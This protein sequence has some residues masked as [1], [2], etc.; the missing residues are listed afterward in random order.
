M[1]L[2]FT[3][4]IA[5]FSGLVPVLLWLWFWE[6]EDNNPEP[7]KLTIYAILAGMVGV[8]I[9]IPI[10]KFIA[11]NFSATLLVFTLWAATEELVKF[12]V[13]YIVVLRRAENDEPVDTVIYLI[14]TALGFSALENALFIFNP[15]SQHHF[16][17]AIITG[18]FRFV[19]AT[20]L[21][22]VA[23]ATIGMCVG[24]AFYKSPSQKRHYLIVGLILS[25]VL[26]TCFNLSIILFDGKTTLLSFLGVWL[27]IVG[28]LFLFEKIKLIKRPLI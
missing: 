22:T 9:V 27:G 2:Y 8:L 12:L 3:I 16:I 10:E 13:A 14:A 21:H 7:A 20:V 4:P 28:L 11:D 17:E 19:G 25:I 18:N 5:F 23:S 1:E 15:L 6:R 26:H 24:Y